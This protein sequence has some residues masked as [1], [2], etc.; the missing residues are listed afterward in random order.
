MGY[1]LRRQLRELLGP[2][3]TGMPRAVALEIADDARRET[4]VSWASLEDLARWTGAKNTD[5]VRDALKRLA[6]AGW[7]FRVPIGKGKDGRLLY[8]V[9]GVKLTFRV[10]DFEGPERPPLEGRVS[11]RPSTQGRVRTP[12]EG[13]TT[14]SEG[15]LTPSEGAE[16]RPFSSTPHD[17]SSLSPRLAAALRAAGVDAGNDER[18]FLEWVKS[19]APAGKPINSVS[20]YLRTCLANGDLARLAADWR[21]TRTATPKRPELPPWCR[22]CGA[23]TGH[24]ADTIRLNKRW[25][26][27]G[28]QPCPACHPDHPDRKE[29][30]TP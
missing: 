23:D 4:R 26:T 24:T 8:A 5:V 30:P 10:P 11:T 19:S 29:G 16:A 18:D 1:E 9:P 13:V 3:I 25:R 27:I 17:S 22:Q 6:A 28:G 7:E 12:T 20:A 21:D 14:P 15:V 2:G